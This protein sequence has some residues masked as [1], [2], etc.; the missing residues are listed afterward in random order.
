MDLSAA[1]L[2]VGCLSLCGINGM[3]DW[4]YVGWFNHWGWQPDVDPV[5][6]VLARF[7]CCPANCLTKLYIIS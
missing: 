3:K 7:T 5:I 4:F 2:W 6:R 1:Y